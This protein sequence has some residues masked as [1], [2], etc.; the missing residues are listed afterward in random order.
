MSSIPPNY[1]GGNI[2]DWRIGK[3]GTMYYPVSVDGALLSAGDTH[4]AQGDSE[5]CGTAIESSWTGLF[6]II[7]HKKNEFE[8]TILTEL[9]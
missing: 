9:N 8:G 6:Q 2:D 1:T 4:A 5:L 3:G 7:L